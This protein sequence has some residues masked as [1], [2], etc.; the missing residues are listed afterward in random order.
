MLKN[1]EKRMDTKMEEQK[2]EFDASLKKQEEHMVRL[3]DLLKNFM[4]KIEA[5]HEQ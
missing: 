4:T 5:K 1:F 2:R 3:E